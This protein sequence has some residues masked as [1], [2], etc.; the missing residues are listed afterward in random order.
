MKRSFQS[1]CPSHRASVHA[2]IHQ[3]TLNGDCPPPIGKKINCPPPFNIK[4]KKEKNRSAPFP[5]SHNDFVKKITPAEP[6]P[7]PSTM[8]KTFNPKMYP[9][10]P[11]PSTFSYIY[12]E[13]KNIHLHPPPPQQ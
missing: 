13:K 3:F 1:I 4:K 11:P 9:F 5:L 6:F 2:F 12:R 7:S 10:P 8:K